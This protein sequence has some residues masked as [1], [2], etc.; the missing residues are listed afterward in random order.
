VGFPV[1]RFDYYGC[2]DSSG[3]AEEGRVSQWLEDTSLAISEVRRRAGLDQVCLVGLRLGGALAMI[4]AEHSDLE[5]MILWDPVVSGKDYLEGLLQLQREMLRFRHK[6]SQGWKSKGPSEVLGFALP[7]LICAELEKIRLLEIAR[8]P[9]KNML[10]VQT[11]HTAAGLRSH[12][13]QTGTQ[14]EFQRLEAP[15]IW[16]PT[17][18]GSL[19]VPG[20]VLQSLVSWTS[21]TH[22]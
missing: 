4:A 10:V 15:Q 13:Q 8:K 18:D 20:L 17:A 5:S 7:P 21:R 22:P 16:R 12:L 6:P 19:L 3:S 2:G 14:L 9:A 1:L 11:E